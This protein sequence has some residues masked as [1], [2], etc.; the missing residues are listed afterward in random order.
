M[1]YS[2]EKPSNSIPHQTPSLNHSLL[3]A[4]VAVGPC[5][6]L[7]SG[8]KERGR[9]SATPA[10]RTITPKTIN[11]CIQSL[12]LWV[13]PAIT[14][15]IQLFSISRR[16]RESRGRTTGTPSLAT[17][18]DNCEPTT[19]LA[20]T[21]YFLTRND[22]GLHPRHAI[23]LRPLGLSRAKQP[24]TYHIGHPVLTEGHDGWDSFAHRDAGGEGRTRSEGVGATA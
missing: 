6:H 18:V 1:R 21:R 5:G 9:P 3:C 15:C 11:I 8:L 19:I 23:L 24:S 10:R 22:S 14:Y 20:D 4:F 17:V 13:T 12:C 16:T 7:T 2:S